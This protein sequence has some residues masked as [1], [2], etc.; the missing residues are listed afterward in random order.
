MGY[1]QLQN[2]FFT[3]YFLIQYFFYNNIELNLFSTCLK[4][5]KI[6]FFL[7]FH[8]KKNKIYILYIPTLHLIII[9]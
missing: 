5:L 3:F 6:Q 4:H 2:Q 8:N 7:F 1:K 9:N